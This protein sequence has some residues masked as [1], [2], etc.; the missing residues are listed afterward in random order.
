MNEFSVAIEG[1]E[2][3]FHFGMGALEKFCEMQKCEFHEMFDSGIFPTEGKGIDPFVFNKLLYAGYLNQCE[4]K[5]ETPELNLAMSY[6]LMDAI[7]N[8][9]VLREKV[10]AVVYSTFKF[11]KGDSKKK[12][13]RKKS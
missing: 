2:Y 9:S 7:F 12:V 11:D 1:K 8:D 3:V 13:V 4:R 10:M 5:E 6:D